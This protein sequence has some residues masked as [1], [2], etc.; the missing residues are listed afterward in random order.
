MAKSPFLAR[1]GVGPGEPVFHLKMRWIAMSVVDQDQKAAGR[2][3]L[4]DTRHILLPAL[5]EA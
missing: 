4:S 1:D 5:L 2:G 3:E